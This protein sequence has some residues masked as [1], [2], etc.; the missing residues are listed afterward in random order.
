MSK[1][2]PG[3]IIS[4][5]FDSFGKNGQNDTGHIVCTTSNVGKNNG[6]YAGHSIPATKDKNGVGGPAQTQFF[7]DG[8][9]KM[10]RDGNQFFR[11]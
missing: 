7:T 6:V 1:L 11:V 9:I 10:F 5:R 8:T 4:W 3:C 2:S